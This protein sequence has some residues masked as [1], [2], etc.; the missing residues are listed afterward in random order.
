MHITI[1]STLLITVILEPRKSVSSRIFVPASA[2]SFS[3]P[4]R[5]VRTSNNV[6]MIFS[7]AALT[8]LLLTYLS[9][10]S[11]VFTLRFGSQLPYPLLEELVAR[12]ESG[13]GNSLGLGDLET[14]EDELYY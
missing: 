13:F 4:G 8:V 12:V 10:I 5:S 11:S 6:W 7:S 2:A 14:E 3:I 9:T 1:S